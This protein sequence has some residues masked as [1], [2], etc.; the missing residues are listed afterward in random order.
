MFGQAR[1]IVINRSWELAPWADILYVADEA[2]WRTYDGVPKFGGLRVTP[3]GRAALTYGLHRV[4]LLPM[5]H[6]DVNRLSPVSR[7]LARGGHSG[8]QAIDLAV[9]LGARRLLLLGLDFI[10]GNWHGSHV[11][12][13]RNSQ[14]HTL[15]KW[16]QRVDDL[17]PLL[18]Q[19]GVDVVNCSQMS[20]LTAYRRA[21]VREALA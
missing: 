20:R 4:D 8:H 1:V 14:Q 10:V 2:F 21:T 3:A 16:R 11:A 7:T 19:R 17:A 15:D 18:S 5:N 9:Q 6:P 12:G 13:L